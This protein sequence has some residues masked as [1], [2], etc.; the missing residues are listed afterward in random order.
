MNEERRMILEMLKD[1]TIDVDEAE[2]LMSAIPDMDAQGKDAPLA[3]VEAGQG[4]NPKRFRIRVDEGGKTK[5]NLTMPFSL[6]RVGFKIA[7]A[8]GPRY[9]EEA[10]VLE[11]IDIDEILASLNS[12]D[13]SLPYTMLNVDDDEKGE[14][15][16]IVLE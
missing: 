8:V 7:K 4:I 15:V 10:K 2:R 14:H 3:K 13:I 11:D 5:V 16:E 1:G 6:V 9:S 12:G